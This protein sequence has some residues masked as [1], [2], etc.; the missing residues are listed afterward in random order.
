[1]PVDTLTSINVFRQVVESGTFVS[2]AARLYLSPA[3]VSKHVMQVEQRHGVRLLKRR[4]IPKSPDDLAH[5]DSMAVA[6]I[7]SWT[8]NGPDGQVE[9]P[10]RAVQR[11]R[12]AVGLA[13]AVAAG[14]GLAPLPTLYFDDPVFKSVLV[15]VL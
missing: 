10:V 3:V 7:G 8:L 14:V 5:H 9:V 12:S 1:M 15:P 6:N 13:H 4:G 11:Y 2:A